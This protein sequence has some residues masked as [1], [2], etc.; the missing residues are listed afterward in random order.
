V[1]GGETLAVPFYPEKAPGYEGRYLKN[2]TDKEIKT[3][4][5][6]E[7]MFKLLEH[8][9]I[10]IIFKGGT[11]TLSEFTTAWCLARLYFGSH[12]P[13]ILYGEH[14]RNIIKVLKENMFLRGKEEKIFKIVSSSQGVLKTIAKFKKR[15]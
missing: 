1:A 13:F 12:K 7:R 15:R 14:W 2:V 4:N 5:Y 6:V 3:G 8:G 10:Y 11:G 9:D